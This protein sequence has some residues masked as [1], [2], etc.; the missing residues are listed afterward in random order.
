MDLNSYLISVITINRNN[1]NGLE[2]TIKSISNQ[3]YKNAQYIVIDGNSNDGSL[4]IIKQNT[5]F[6]SFWV[7]EPDRGIYN[8][9][10]KAIE[11]ATGEYLL[12]VNSGDILYDDSILEM[13]ATA[14]FSEDFVYGDIIFED[15]NEVLIMPDQITLKT[16]LGSSIG[17]GATFIKR[18]LF[19][20]LGLYNESNIIVSDWEF[21]LKAFLKSSCSYK[22]IDRIFTVYQKGGI[23]TNSEYF[24]VQ[25]EERK[26]ALMRIF[27]EFYD[28]INENIELKKEL[29]FYKNSRIIQLVKNIQA[30]RL[31]RFR[32]SF[33]FK[34]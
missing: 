22:H 33:R 21:F 17:H 28:I 29:D 1:S 12:F 30:S 7:S 11:I 3:T 6:L 14:N 8:A 23:S 20:K 26:S 10:N 32:N 25:N 34:R 9:M 16:F 24:H 2:K 13:F 15:S 27:P 31:N 4:E 5:D 18:E 19:N